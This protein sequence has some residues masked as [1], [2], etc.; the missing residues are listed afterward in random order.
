MVFAS[1]QSGLCLYTLYK[2]EQKIWHLYSFYTNLGKKNTLRFFFRLF[3]FH[4][5]LVSWAG[6]E[7]S[8]RKFVFFSKSLWNSIQN[9]KKHLFST[10]H[11][12]A[13]CFHIVCLSLDGHKV[14]LSLRHRTHLWG[15]SCRWVS[16]PGR[17]CPR[18]FSSCDRPGAGSGRWQTGDPLL[19]LRWELGRKETGI[20]LG[21]LQITSDIAKSAS[22]AA[23]PRARVL[24]LGV[25]ALS[26]T[27]DVTGKGQDCFQSKHRIIT[28]STLTSLS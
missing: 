24:S 10:S 13:Q 2:T 22:R 16:S 6:W 7:G 12:R 28:C 11:L 9:I 19:L 5:A 8:R 14:L 20:S 26:A 27:A 3:V 18:P 23:A 15:L 25:L 4:W 21:Q 1:I 17:N